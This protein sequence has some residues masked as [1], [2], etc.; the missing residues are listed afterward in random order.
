M[1]ILSAIGA[2]AIAIA[3]ASII[4]LFGGF[5]D[6]SAAKD[7]N[8]ALAWTLQHVRERSIDGH[9]S[10]RPTPVWFGDPT[11]IKAGARE[12]SEEGCVVCHGAPGHK[13][14][15][16]AE[17]MDPKP[18]DLAKVG[19]DNAPAKMFWIVKNGIR[20]TGMPAFGHHAT[21]DEIWRAVAFVRHMDSVTPAQFKKMEHREPERER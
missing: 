11:T 16:F 5:Y 1:R 15:H 10:A 3:I 6:I 13:P 9:Y 2:L 20:M 12:F 14:E 4:Y 18:P 21:D 8:P 7:A 19:K 17:G